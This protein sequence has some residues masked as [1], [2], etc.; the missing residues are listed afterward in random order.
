MEHK[1]PFV[2]LC[3]SRYV[4]RCGDTTK[5]KVYSNQ[6]QVT[7]LVDGREAGTVQVTESL[8]LRSL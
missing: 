4:E 2:H 7:L 5:I 8:Y 3:G 6:Q 1:E